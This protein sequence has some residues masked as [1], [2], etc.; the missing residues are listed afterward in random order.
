MNLLCHRELTIST[1]M[2]DIV[3]ARFMFCTFLLE[4]TKPNND[5]L[6]VF[7]EYVDWHGEHCEDFEFVSN[8]K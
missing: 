7:F 6:F 3:F 8:S 1:V 2:V 4:M 5:I